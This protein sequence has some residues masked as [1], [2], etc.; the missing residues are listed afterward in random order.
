[1]YERSIQGWKKISMLKKINS[2]YKKELTIEEVIEQSD[3]FSKV[4]KVYVILV[5]F[6]SVLNFAQSFIEVYA[7][8]IFLPLSYLV[9]GISFVLLFCFVIVTF[10]FA[11]KLSKLLP[12][13]FEKKFRR[14]KKTY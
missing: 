12:E 6:I 10:I 2:N 14:V 8:E 3:K 1:M 7:R 11:K 4:K 5:V 9:G 13:Q